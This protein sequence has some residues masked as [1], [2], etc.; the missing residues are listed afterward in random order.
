L[1]SSNPASNKR[2][3]LSTRALLIGLVQISICGLLLLAWQTIPSGRERFWFSSPSEIFQALV[4]WWS[5]GTLWYHAWSTLV[6]MAMGYAIGATLGIGSGILLGLNEGLRGLLSPFIFAFYS[7]PTIALAPLFI[8]VLGIDI[9]SKIALVAVTVFFL[10]LIN[11]LEGVRDI[12]RDLIDSVRIIGAERDETIRLVVLPAILPWIFHGMKISVRYAFSGALLAELISA[13]RGIGF[14]LQY[15]S[16]VMN[17]TRAFAAVVI[18]VVLN[19]L[20]TLVV[21]AVEKYLSRH[22]YGVQGGAARGM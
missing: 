4:N 9:Q 15:N 8:V 6:E 12:D 20:I 10:I 11:V 13:N 22:G 1:R 21:G 17:V 7:L 19:L 14:L 2:R 18:M 16:S 3:K 5:D